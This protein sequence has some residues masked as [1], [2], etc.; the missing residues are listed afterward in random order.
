MYKLLI[1]FALAT[2][3]SAEIVDLRKYQTP[4][5]NQKDRNTCAYFAVTALVEGVIKAQFNKTYD[6]SEQFQIFYGKEHFN[7]YT[8]KEF[9]YTYEIAQ[10]FVKQ[11]F[12]ITEDHIPYQTSFFESGQ[13]CENED[14]FDTS[15]P[16]F[17]FSQGPI[18]Y[19]H[20]PRVKLD[21][22]K[23]DWITAMW[24]FGSTRAQLIQER[25][26][27]KRPVVITLKVYAPQWKDKLVTYTAETD[28]KCENGTFECYGHAVLLTGYDTKRKVF[29]FKNSWGEKWGDKGYGEISFDYINSYSD[30]P[31]S[32]YF[33]RLLGGIRE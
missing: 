15:A 33:D 8:D 30:E 19:K 23:Y 4:V 28:K 3:A 20:F 21:G 32:V 1:L 2:M 18:K 22:L 6:I 13:P 24:S 5:K 17:C 27:K 25:I 16:S 11:Y 7:E 10:N 31:L 9:G 26:K 12:F 29:Y 14:P